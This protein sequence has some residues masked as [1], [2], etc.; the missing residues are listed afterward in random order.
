MKAIKI[1]IL[2]CLV[3][4]AGFSLLAL[5]VVT[6]WLETPKN[7]LADSSMPT[8]IQ[9][10]QRQYD[11]LDEQSRTGF[12]YRL[13]TQEGIRD[14]SILASVKQSSAM[15]KITS[16]GVLLFNG[17]AAAGVI[18][19][20]VGQKKQPTEDYFTKRGYLL[21]GVCEDLVEVLKKQKQQPN[22]ALGPTPITPCE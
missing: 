18:Y 1:V 17:L 5:W 9:N 10:V 16:D 6:G 3:C 4:S 8:A 19:L 7:A 11:S 20:L 2:V 12:F 15:T 13:L 22:T 14:S 21:P